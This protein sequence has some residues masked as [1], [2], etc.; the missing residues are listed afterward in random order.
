MVEGMSCDQDDDGDGITDVLDNCPLNANPQQSDADADGSGDACDVTDSPLVP[1]PV[2]HTSLAALM[3]N[4][5]FHRHHGWQRSIC[6]KQKKTVTYPP[7]RSELAREAFTQTTL[8]KRHS[9][10][11][12]KCRLA[13]Q[14]TGQTQPFF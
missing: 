3:V 9:T 7:D 11:Q 6:C 12:E 4:G 1:I 2:F 13:L 10:A 14:T 8:K 5:T